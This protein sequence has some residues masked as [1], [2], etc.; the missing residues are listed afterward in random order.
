MH[1]SDHFDAGNIEV[2]DAGDPAAVRLAIRADS[3]ADFFQWFHFRATGVAGV[4]C[5]FRIENAGEASYTKGWE[6]YQAVASYDREDWFRVPTEYSAGVLTIRHTPE[7]DSVY[8][9]YF[10]PYSG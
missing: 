6:G 7:R 8:Y 3:N 9:A 2:I 5:A 4:E 1:I 10:E